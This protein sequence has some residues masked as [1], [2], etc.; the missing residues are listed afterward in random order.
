MEYEK[1]V[2][3]KHAHGENRYKVYQGTAYHEDTPDDVVLLLESLRK[4]KARIVLDYGNTETGESWGEK[5]DISGSIGRSNGKIKVPLLIHNIRS[6]GGGSVLDH[7]IIGIYTSKG[8]I[9]LYRLKK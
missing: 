3:Y 2:S 6:M 7:C 9:P 4:S 5:Y 1:N 8:K